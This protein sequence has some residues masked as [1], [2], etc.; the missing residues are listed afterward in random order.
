M[1]RDR[2]VMAG[3]TASVLPSPQAV[4]RVIAAPFVVAPPAGVRVRTRL[5]PSPA[6]DAALTAMGNLLGALY[7]QTLADRLTLGRADPKARA[8]WRREA[9]RSLTAR[10]SSR[11]AGALTRAAEDQYQ[12][13]M[14]SLAAE[15]T[16]L[17][18]ATATLRARV[19]VAPG[20]RDGRIKGY[21]SRVERHAKTRRLEHLTTRLTAATTALGAGRPSLSVGGGRLWS[22][23]ENLAAANLTVAQWDARWA[24]ARSF[25]TADGESGKR[26]GNE[27]I[28]VGG[29]GTVTIKVPADLVPQFGT[30]LTL[31][32]AVA[33]THRGAEWADRVAANHAVRYDITFDPIKG[34]W[35][36]DASW[37]YPPLPVVPLTAL[38]AGRVLG[39]DLNADHLAAFVLDPSGNPTGKPVTIPLEVTGLAASTRSAR[40]R[41]AISEL[42]RVTAANGCAAIAIENLNF[43]DARA[44]GRETMGRGS[45]GKTFRRTVSGIPTGH[46]RDRLA[47][48]A[49]TAGIAVIAVDP[50]YTSR[51]GDQ[52]WRT[53]VT[54][55]DPDATRHHAASVAIGRRALGYRIRRRQGKGPARRQ[56]TASS[57]PTLRRPEPTG[58]AGTSGTNEHR[59]TIPLGHSLGHS[60]QV[61][62]TVR[63]TT[64]QRD[65]LPLTG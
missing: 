38:Q 45:R 2:A 12:L 25:L 34:R 16:Y 7:R 51:W 39:V 14:R 58:T 53:A 52:H 28:R 59:D 11:W 17:R 44:T 10:S 49:A 27:T 63:G 37:G 29:D 43:A 54:S 20:D 31:T 5:R 26:C 62:K 61:P 50:A 55:S 35:Y 41:E 15:V 13:G 8:D 32:A 23:R 47:G 48:M 21:R 1:R 9:K 4:L 36:I 65:P 6:E 42:L 64:A 46:F 33:F 3:E 22:A 40:M 57:T 56:R 30:H 18:S 24:A 60:G 19:D